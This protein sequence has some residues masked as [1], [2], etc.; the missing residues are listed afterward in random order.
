MPS[1][2]SRP[3][4]KRFAQAYRSMQLSSTLFGV[5]IVQIKPHLERL[6]KIPFDGLLKEIQLTQDLLSMLIEYQ[7][8]GD[9]LSF[10]GPPD[11][12]LEVRLA[13]V[14]SNVQKIK[15]IIAVEKAEEV[16]QREKEEKLRRLVQG[17]QQEISA[18]QSRIDTL[19]LPPPNSAPMSYISSAG[20][21]GSFGGGGGGGGGMFMADG[22]A[23][24][25]SF[26]ECAMLSDASAGEDGGG[27]VDQVDVLAKK[28]EAKEGGK[29]EEGQEGGKKEEL[30]VV[31]EEEEGEGEDYTKIPQLLETKFKVFDEDNTLRPTIIN[32]GEIWSK[33]SYAT[34]LSKKATTTLFAEGQETAC[35][36]AFDLLDALSRSG[37]NPLQEVSLHTIIV[38]SHCF[39]KTLIDTV[40]QDNVNPI[41]KVERS[42]LILATTIQDKPAKELVREDQLERV[43]KYSPLF[44]VEQEALTF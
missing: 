25:S 31:D 24:F 38:S 19:N 23:D 16:R 33:D 1:N 17:K 27:G 28:A 20:A 3:S 32:V 30:M 42:N 15:N 40:I 11:A 39:D 35:A 5:C 8:P 7:I 36:R 14:K 9:L 43:S 12:T 22:A 41:E 4:K 13:Q 6:L 2:R 18:L 37:G 44:F 26:A 34:L 29:K 21:Y 10:Q